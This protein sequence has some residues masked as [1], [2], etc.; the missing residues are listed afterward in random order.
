MS[1]IVK[2]LLK[3]LCFALAAVQIYRNFC[4]LDDDRA[5][6]REAIECLACVV[7]IFLA[8]RLLF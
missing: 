1:P 5:V 6:I 4:V 7:F 3:G 2:E 8:D